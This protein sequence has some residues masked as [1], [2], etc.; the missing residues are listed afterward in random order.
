MLARPPSCRKKRLNNLAVSAI[1]PARYAHFNHSTGP[2]TQWCL[3]ACACYPKTAPGTACLAQVLVSCIEIDIQ[4]LSVG[5][6][7][8][9]A[10]LRCCFSCHANLPLN[11]VPFTWIQGA[12][13]GFQ[14]FSVTW[15]H[16]EE[17]IFGTLYRLRVW[18]QVF[19]AWDTS[20][21]VKKPKTS[22]A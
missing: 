4:E 16:S 19:Q 21:T 3:Q 17:V 12:C 1:G 22:N 14:D 11:L 18:R 10:E 9:Q 20:S 15:C 13:H 2:V 8:L 5:M 6:R 7:Q